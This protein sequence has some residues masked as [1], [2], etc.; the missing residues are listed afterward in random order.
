LGDLGVISLFGTDDFATLPL[1]MARALGAYRSND[2]AG[3]AA[4]MLI[5]TIAA[6][7]LIPKLFGRFS[8]A[9]A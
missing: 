3:I 2:A 5:V 9:R 7:V 8:D 6:F 4:V 1:L